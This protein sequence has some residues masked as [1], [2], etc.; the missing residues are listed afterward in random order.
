MITGRGSE[1]CVPSVSLLLVETRGVEFLLLN[2]TSSRRRVIVMH[3]D[4]CT[5]AGVEGGLHGPGAQVRQVRRGQPRV[6]VAP[7]GQV[8]HRR[9]VVHAAVRV[10]AGRELRHHEGRAR[11]GLHRHV[12][13]A[14]RAVRQ[15]PRAAQG[16]GRA[17]GELQP[18]QP[19]AFFVGHDREPL[20]DAREHPELQPRRDGLQRGGSSPWIWPATCCRPAAP[21][22]PW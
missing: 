6:P 5:C 15:V 17:G 1:G 4:T 19:H 2:V 9:R 7:S 8:W 3:A 14:G 11:G 22:W 12:R 16:R 20:Q 10:R 18:V 21:G 13:G